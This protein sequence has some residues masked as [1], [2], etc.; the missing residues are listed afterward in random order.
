M[1]LLTRAVQ[2]C[3]FRLISCDGGQRTSLGQQTFHWDCWRCGVEETAGDF[4]NLSEAWDE[5][6][7]L[8]WTGNVR[9]AIC[10]RCARSTTAQAD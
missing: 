3:L 6:E 8:G 10:P 5:M 7:R 4:R 9:R 2:W 1:G